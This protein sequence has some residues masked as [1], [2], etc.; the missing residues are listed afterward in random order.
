MST[1]LRP[2]PTR[3]EDA[4]VKVPRRVGH[5]IKDLVDPIVLRRTMLW[6]VGLAVVALAV[7]GVIA[8]AAFLRPPTGEALL[9]DAV[10]AAGGM[11]PWHAVDGGTFTRVHTVFDEDEQPVRVVTERHAFRYGDD[12]GI[13]M[14]TS[15]GGD[16][17]RIGRSNSGYW[18]TL[19]GELV[20]PGPLAQDMDMMCES[21]LCTPTCSM[22]LAFYRF[23]MPFKLTDP[24]VV[25]TYGGSATLAGRPVSL[26]N[27][28]FEEGVGG[29]RWTLYVDD[30]T[31]LIRKIDYY[32]NADLEAVDTPPT[33][34]YWSDHRPE[35]GLVL[36]HRQTYYRSNGT[37]LEEYVISDVDLTSPVSEAVFEHPTGDLALA[38]Q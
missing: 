27:I 10:E 28:G 21:D 22:E 18:A 14:E 9:A 32:E 24:G 15:G 37:K 13:V 36:S 1:E 12:G 7:V 6:R 23:S 11:A 25:P 19:N 5:E 35:D 20:A 4:P 8:W 34:I 16:V 29:D 3:P 17:A 26:L 30:E 2:D 31:K 33:E 38:V